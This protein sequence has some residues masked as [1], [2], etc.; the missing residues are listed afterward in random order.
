[1]KIF[2]IIIVVILTSVEQSSAF[3]YGKDLVLKCP[4]NESDIK[5][6]K[7]I[8]NTNKTRTYEQLKDGFE[9]SSKVNTSKTFTFKNVVNIDII[10]PSYFC[11]NIN[12]TMYELKVNMKPHI[13]EP[14]KRVIQITPGGKLNITCELL[15]PFE[16]ESFQWQWTMN[17]SQINV[18][19]SFIFFDNIKE[20]DDG[21]YE[22]MAINSFGI[23]RRFI[24]V[25]IVSKI[26]L[27]WLFLIA[28]VLV[29]IICIISLIIDKKYHKKEIKKHLE[30]IR[31]STL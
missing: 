15:K 8:I 28:F 27:L 23:Y 18:N 25:V 10:N 24:T 31:I 1:M 30:T 3:E 22:C 12:E 29:F 4:S 21:K 5:L 7:S 14:I 13:L 16:N 26:T 19:E 17:G 2:F 6:Y 20:S 11:G 9:S